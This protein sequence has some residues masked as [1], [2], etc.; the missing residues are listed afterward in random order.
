[1]PSFI[2]LQYSRTFL[3]SQRGVQTIGPTVCNHSGPQLGEF[4]VPSSI[5]YILAPRKAL[6]DGSVTIWPGSAEVS[7][8]LESNNASKTGS[9]DPEAEPGLLD[10]SAIRMCRSRREIYSAGFLPHYV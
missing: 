2:A 6:R 3:I 9:R 5:F 10:P 1:M 8:L 7:A 4:A